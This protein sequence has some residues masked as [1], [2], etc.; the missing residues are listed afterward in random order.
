M[1]LIGYLEFPSFLQYTDNI[2]LYKNVS[3]NQNEDCIKYENINNTFLNP[4][5]FPNNNNDDLSFINEG[6][7][8][9]LE[10]PN[11]YSKTI[12]WTTDIKKSF[13]NC[14][15]PFYN[16]DVICSN[17][18]DDTV[19]EDDD[20]IQSFLSPFY[21]EHVLKLTFGNFNKRVR[22]TIFYLVF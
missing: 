1:Y 6:K 17:N 2:K 18:D 3:L 5:I 15:L 10:I 4:S 20:K 19:I 14:C 22:N 8:N 16:V 7:L 21:V 13:S 9:I 11:Y 12:A